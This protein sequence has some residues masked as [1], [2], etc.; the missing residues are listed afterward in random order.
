MRLALSLKFIALTRL[1]Y[2]ANGATLLSALPAPSI[3]GYTLAPE[4]ST[5][6][7]DLEVGTARQRRRTRSAPTTVSL[8]WR[9]TDAQFTQF[10]QWYEGDCAAGASWFNMDLALGE[11]GINSTECRF[12]GAYKASALP[13]LNWDVSASVEVR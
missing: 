12:K 7:T 3:S 11:S 10:K 13:G 4:E 2:V 9:M 8:S 1:G 6:R 5:I